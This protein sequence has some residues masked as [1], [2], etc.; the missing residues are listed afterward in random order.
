MTK[1][2]APS[3]TARAALS[4]SAA[5]AAALMA[6]TTFS[7]PA[8][9][10]GVRVGFGFP[11]GAFVAHRYESDRGYN[12]YRS[13][14]RHRQA[15]SAAAVRA[16]EERK[17][18]ARAKIAE[19]EAQ[20]KAAAARRLAAAKKKAQ[21]ASVQLAKAENPGVTSDAAPAIFVPDTPSVATTSSV[22]APAETTALPVIRA[23][24]VSEEIKA[25]A[26][27]ATE[28]ATTTPATTT[29]A[30]AETT[31]PVKRKVKVA[32]RAK[33]ACRRF[34]ALI[35]DLVDVPCK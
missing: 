5:F 26:A 13:A 35:G 12:D 14:R 9:A 16:A 25:E 8:S 11:L 10:H 28:T 23:V 17:R 33:Q 24:S 18:A 29:G 3:H 22:N 20:K 1:T 21:H 4:A 31:V 30:I 19:S 2:T 7:A 32:E 6:T 15:Q 27:D 34:S